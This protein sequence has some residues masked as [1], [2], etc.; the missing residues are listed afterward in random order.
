ML[1]ILVRFLRRQTE[2][3][4]AGDMTSLLKLLSGKHTVISQLQKLDGDL[5]PFRDEDPERRIWRSTAERAACQAR[6]RACNA[7]LA[8]SMA[9]EQQAETAM[10]GRRDAAAATLAA[11]QTASDARAAYAAIPS[12]ALTSL[13]VEG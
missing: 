12:P 2:L 4:E 10:R 8:E 7:L 3:I 6:C 11:V 5:T 9:L 1:E 13:H